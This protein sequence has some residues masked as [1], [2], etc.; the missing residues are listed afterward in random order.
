[1]PY[2]NVFQDWPLQALGSFHCVWAHSLL[3][4]ALV[5]EWSHPRH[6]VGR[7]CLA[8][9]EKQSDKSISA[10]CFLSP[11]QAFKTEQ[12]TR[13]NLSRTAKSIS[14]RLLIL[15]C[16]SCDRWQQS[17][18]HWYVVQKSGRWS[19]KKQE[20][21][22]LKSCWSHAAAFV[23]TLWL[24]MSRQNTLWPR[25]LAPRVYRLKVN[26]LSKLLFLLNK[27]TPAFQLSPLSFG[28]QI[29][30]AFH[31]SMHALSFQIFLLTAV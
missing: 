11:C 12:S 22:S 7:C 6:H 17:W 16:W 21:N 30:W 5:L 31:I 14:W 2:R 25:L 15:C 18:E 4:A 26:A 8:L 24:K 28:F 19:A 3:V 29:S 23:R 13:W 20:Q 1:M 9:Q 10:I 27:E